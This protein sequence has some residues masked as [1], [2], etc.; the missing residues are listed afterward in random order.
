[1]MNGMMMDGM[2][3][4]WMWIAWILPFALVMGLVVVAVVLVARRP[5]GSA[6][7]PPNAPIQGVEPPLEILKRRYAKGEVDS[8]EFERIKQEILE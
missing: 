5:G 4:G 3:M 7:L 6:S 2:M 1:M 8:K